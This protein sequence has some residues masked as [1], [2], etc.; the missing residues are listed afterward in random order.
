MAELDIHLSDDRIWL[1]SPP[2]G[3]ALSKVFEDKQGRFVLDKE[4]WNKF[5]RMISLKIGS[6]VMFC[7]TKDGGDDLTM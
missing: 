7:F 5:A 1:H 2:R 4:T 3:L 6:D